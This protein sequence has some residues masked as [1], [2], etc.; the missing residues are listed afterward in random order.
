MKLRNNKYKQERKEN[1]IKLNEIE[2]FPF[3]FQSL[4]RKRVLKKAVSTNKTTKIIWQ[5]TAVK[6]RWPIASLQEGRG[7]TKG[8]F[9]N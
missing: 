2:S 7:T 6:K 1:C 3:F 5:H 9:A 8:R 4:Q